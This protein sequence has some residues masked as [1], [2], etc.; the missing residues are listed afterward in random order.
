MQ[1]WSSS[2]RCTSSRPRTLKRRKTRPFT[3]TSPAQQTPTT[4]ARCS[5]TW[6]TRCSSSLCRNMACCDQAMSW[7]LLKTH[8]TFTFFQCHLFRKFFCLIV[9]GGRH[10]T[11]ISQHCNSGMGQSSAKEIIMV[12]L[13]CDNEDRYL[14]VSVF[15]PVCVQDNNAV[16]KMKNTLD[17]TFDCCSAGWRDYV[18]V[19][20]QRHPRRWRKI[21]LLS[22]RPFFSWKCLFTSIEKMMQIWSTLLLG[23]HDL[24]VLQ[25]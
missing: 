24:L 23:L 9:L 25:L 6:K 15:L 10:G 21:W 12:S 5:A 8:L 20:T 2:V 11:D 22:M 1:P 17:F 3:R 19:Y 16:V 13:P 18:S 4:S 14:W 7:L